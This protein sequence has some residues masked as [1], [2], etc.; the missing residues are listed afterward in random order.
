LKLC[1]RIQRVWLTLAMSLASACALSP[2]S[3]QDTG[4]SGPV[5]LVRGTEPQTI[6]VVV[7]HPD[8]ENLAGPALSRLAR[9]GHR[10]RVVIATDGKY[11]TRLT[12]MAPEALGAVRRKES[13]C[14]LEALGLPPPVFLSIDRLD[15]RNGVRPYLDGRR[16][17]LS[18]LHAELMTIQPDAILTFGPDGEYGH[19]EHIVVGGAITEVLLREGLVETYP[20]Y[21]FLWSREQVSDDEDLSYVASEYITHKLVH[22]DDDEAR[23]FAA[24]RCYASQMSA[25]EI[26]ELVRRVSQD[27][28]NVYFF[29]RFHA[30]TSE[31]QPALPADAASPRG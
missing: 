15:T 24:A 3:S 22:T 23:S 30:V 16:R 11:G 10:V 26:D 12:N 25:A 19:P 7:A 17:L 6:L 1:V 20:L 28:T 29:R 13:E 2:P 14:A 31:A 27:K 8:D 5:D 4:E 9:L 21:Y 18:A